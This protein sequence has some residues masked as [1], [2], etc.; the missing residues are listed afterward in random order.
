M[1]LQSNTKLYTI[2]YYLDVCWIY[3]FPFEFGKFGQDPQAPE[4]D[5][6][7]SWICLTSIVN[8]AYLFFFELSPIIL[9]AEKNLATRHKTSFVKVLGDHFVT[10]ESWPKTNKGKPKI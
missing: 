6:H 1:F 2:L 4:S 10:S 9:K 5:H 7:E 3:L 8:I